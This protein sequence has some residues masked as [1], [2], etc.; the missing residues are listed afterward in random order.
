MSD[1]E[2]GGGQGNFENIFICPLI[3]RLTY[4]PPPP[5]ARHFSIY[6]GATLVL[7]TYGHLL[8]E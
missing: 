2:E 1:R 3:Q 8:I 5:R 6:S 4:C 7:K